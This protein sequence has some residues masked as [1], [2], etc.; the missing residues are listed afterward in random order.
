MSRE[1]IFEWCRDR[2]NVNRITDDYIVLATGGHHYVKFENGET[3]ETKLKEDDYG[4]N[5]TQ[6]TKINGKLVNRSFYTWHNFGWKLI[7]EEC[8]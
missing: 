7:K 5:E 1:E 4:D 6:E 3:Y 2:L 8:F